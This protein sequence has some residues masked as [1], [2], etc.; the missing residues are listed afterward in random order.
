M[1]GSTIAGMLDY[2]AEQN[3]KW[4]ANVLDK[5]FVFFR[6]KVNDIAAYIVELHRYLTDRGFLAKVDHTTRL[7][8][9]FGGIYIGLMNGSSMSFGWANRNEAF[10]AHLLDF[11]RFYCTDLYYFGNKKR[12]KK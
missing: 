12:E 2:Q 11:H 8:V 1:E 6:F 5:Q 10:L 3:K 7:Q 9:S 4:A